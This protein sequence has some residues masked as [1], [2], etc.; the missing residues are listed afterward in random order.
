MTYDAEFRDNI[1]ATPGTTPGTSVDVKIPASSHVG[2]CLVAAVFT[3][4]GTPT[5][6]PISTYGAWTQFGFKANASNGASVTLFRK[7][8]AQGDLDNQDQ[9]WTTSPGSRS[10]ALCAAYSDVDLLTP[11]DV[12]IVSNTGTSQAPSAGSLSPSAGQTGDVAVFLSCLSIAA[13]A[14][15]PSITWTPPSGFSHG[16]STQTGGTSGTG[17]CYGFISDDKTGASSTGTMTA[18]ISGG[19]NRQW[20]TVAL[21]LRQK[22]ANTPPVVDA[23][24]DQSVTGNDIVALAMTASDPDGDSLTKSW[25]QT[26]GTSASLV[27]HGDGTAGFTAPNVGDTLTFQATAFDGTTSTSD[28]MQVTITRQSVF[29][30]TQ[31][32]TSFAD[33]T[34]P[35]TTFAVVVPATVQFGDVVYII[36]S[37][38]GIMSCTEGSGTWSLLLSLANSSNGVTTRVYRKVMDPINDAGASVTFTLGSSGRMWIDCLAYKDADVTTPEDVAVVSGVGTSLAPTAPTATPATDNDTSLVIYSTSLA[39]PATSLA[40]TVPSGYGDAL[41]GNTSG[42]TGGGNIYVAVYDKP[43]GTGTAG[44]ATGTTASSINQSRQWVGIRVLIRQ[45]TTDT[46]PVPDAG[47]DQT[48]IEPYTTVTLVGTASDAEGDTVSLAWAEDPGDSP[49]VAD[50]SDNGSG[51]ATFTAPPVEAGWTGTFILT[52]NDGTD[53]ATDSCTVTVLPHNQWA[54]VGSTLVPIRRQAIR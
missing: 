53:T 10:A 31:R 43:L 7:P 19:T 6:T 5:I 8:C 1:A 21:L 12:A 25:I 3:N 48:T 41:V 47:P 52:A 2:D 9:T 18:G 40:W 46:P 20:A 15:P 42:S 45:R 24:V 54:A 4:G 16:L 32:A 50:L 36:A 26:G 14:G 13:A 38:N 28:T 49:Q 33:G 22:S 34:S 39:V 29:D 11:L 23:G 51:V 35:G 37:A 27:D 44:N 17:N 30:L